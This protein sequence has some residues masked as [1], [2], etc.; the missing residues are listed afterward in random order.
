[1]ENKIFECRRCRKRVQ[2]SV[3]PDPP[4][5]CNQPMAAVA[6]DQCTHAA[7]PEHARFDEPDEP[8]DDGRAG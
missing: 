5:C 8:C 3:Q 6:I 4:E 1:M 2:A 7:T